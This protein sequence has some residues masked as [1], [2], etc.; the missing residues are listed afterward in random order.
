MRVCK[1]AVQLLGK[2]LSRAMVAGVEVAIEVHDALT[3]S[4]QVRRPTR[5]TAALPR[6]LALQRKPRAQATEPSSPNAH[7]RRPSGWTTLGARGGS[8]SARWSSSASW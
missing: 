7:A 8:C 2:S 5:L 4:P 6:C 1:R 3:F